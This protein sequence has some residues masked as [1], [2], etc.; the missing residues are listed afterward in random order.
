MA[1]EATDEGRRALRIAICQVGS[2]IAEAGSDPRPAN[3]ARAE[4]CIVEATAAGAQLVLFGEVF[5]N[6][7]RSDGH[8]SRFSTSLTPPDEHLRRLTEVCRRTGAY[9]AM[10]ISRRGDDGLGRLYNSAVL[11]GPEGVV[12]HYDKVH[13]GTFELPSGGLVMEGAYWDDG[14]EMKVFDLPWCRIGLQICRDVRYPE[15][16]RAV[17]L[18]GAEVIVNLSAALEERTASWDLLSRTR[19]VENQAWFV[20]ASVV[21]GQKE[22]RLVG[23]S[24]VVDPEGNV[25][26]RVPDHAE[27]IAYAD[28]DLSRLEELRSASH[29]LARRVPSAYLV[30]RGEAVPADRN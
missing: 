9:V 6:G 11:V 20:M 7:Y 18:A 14:S 21:G 22:T 29:L 24:R 19:A 1:G 16:S 10:G 8:L 3:L 2:E 13:V 17:V 25:V 15:A 27:Q 12:G 28:L 26:L 4:E 5:L 23:A 30:R